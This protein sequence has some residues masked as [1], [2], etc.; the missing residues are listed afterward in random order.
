MN[1]P[2]AKSPTDSADPTT[3]PQ[4]FSEMLQAFEEIQM[5]RTPFALEKLVVGAEFTVE[6]QYAKCVL[7]M[8]VAYDNLRLAKLG[9]EKKQLEI[10]KID[11]SD[12]IG[13]ID[14]QIKTIEQEQTKRAMLG[15]MREFQVL[16]N[17]WRTFPKKFTREDLNAASPEY[18]TQRLLT[19]ANHDLLANGRVGVSNQEGLRQIDRSWQPGDATARLLATQPA[20]TPS[21]IAAEQPAQPSLLDPVEQRYLSQGK[22]RMLVAVPTEKKAVNG[23]PCLEGVA[24][25]SG[26]EI[27]LFNNYGNS[28]ADAYTFIVRQALMDDADY[29][30]TIEDDTFPPPDAIVRL[31]ALLHKQLPKNPRVAV[32]AWYPKR[33]EPRQGVHII[34]GDRERGPL[35]DDGMV[36]EVHTLA[37]GCTIYPIQIFRDVPEPWFK[38]TPHLSQDSYFSQKARDAGWTLLVDTNIKCRHIDR[39]T[40]K[41]YE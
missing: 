28:I 29:L 24:F 15:A 1:P 10:A 2:D 7:E 22:C 34:I 16:Y 23:L 6:Q 39:V 30:V 37:M 25:P 36:H 31:L 5:P 32:G 21:L 12:P 14:V 20:S 40:G 3:D 8:S 18:Y 38:T 4:I 35:K 27:K 41:V 19:Q 13:K 11:Q 9:V 17:L 33:E 26:V